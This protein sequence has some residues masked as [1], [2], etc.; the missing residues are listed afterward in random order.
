MPNYNNGK[1]YKIVNSIDDMIYI[2]STTCRLCSRMNV[3]RVFAKNNHNANLYRYMRELGITNFTIVLI[4]N[5]PCSSKEHL[6]RRERH[7]F[8][9]HDKQILLNSNRPIVSSIEKKQ[10]IRN[11]QMDNKEYHANQMRNWRIYNKEYH[12]NQMKLW[13]L[14]NKTY[15]N[16]CCR[17]YYYF[18]KL[19][20]E[21]PFYRIP[22]TTSF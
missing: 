1:I 21:L 5:Y 22:L 7:V 18:N 4:E 11:W 14:N 3:H 17:K 19:M 16:E 6:L 8:D 2:G 10:Q 15:H 13:F 20:Q 12:T 9:L